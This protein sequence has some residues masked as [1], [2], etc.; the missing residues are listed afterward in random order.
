[1]QSPSQDSAIRRLTAAKWLQS[2][3]GQAVP[4]LHDSHFRQALSSGVLLCDTL[5][6][7]APGSVR[8]VRSCFPKL[9]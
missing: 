4:G 9:L 3:S 7:F 8:Q 2:V 1:M 5:N 6:A